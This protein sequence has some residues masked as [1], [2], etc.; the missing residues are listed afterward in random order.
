M[1]ALSW[2]LTIRLLVMIGKLMLP[3]FMFTLVVVTCGY[4][5]TNTDKLLGLHCSVL[6]FCSNEKQ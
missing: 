5:A 3:Y 4:V 6:L 2:H 1:S